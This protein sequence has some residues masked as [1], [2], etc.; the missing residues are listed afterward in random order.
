MSVLPTALADALATRL[1][2]TVTAVERVGGGCINEAARFRLGGDTWFV[3][4]RHGA[5]PGFFEAESDGLT[6][7]A[8]TGTVLVPR[9]EHAG[10]VRADPSVTY[11]LMGWIPPG[12]AESRPSAQRDAGRRLAELHAQRGL[13]PGLPVDNWIGALP[14]RNPAA[15]GRGWVRWFV[16]ERVG[17]LAGALPTRTRAGLDR[18][19]WEREL[20][21][22]DGGCALLHGDLWGGNL[23]CGADGRGWLVDP[24]VYAGHP[25]VDLAMT[26]LFGGFD[27]GFDAA[28]QEVA[29]RF[30]AG[31]EVRLSLLNVYPLLVH[32]HLF[33]GGYAAQIQAIVDRHAH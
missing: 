33:G 21:E 13:Q 27:S 29:G 28:Y 16:E 23:V 12:S 25:E 31:I 9:V 7:L 24:A 17:R 19:D 10:D 4:W 20:T 2:G 32:V 14:Q 1:G 26:R 3:K 11:L 5:P 18:I 30:D 15:N 6:R 8:A 22:P